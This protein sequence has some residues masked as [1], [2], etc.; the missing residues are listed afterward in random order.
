MGRLGWDYPILILSVIGRITVLFP[1]YFQ[2]TS[3]I[4]RSIDYD[5]GSRNCGLKS[6][7][8]ADWAVLINKTNSDYYQHNVVYCEYSYYY[9]YNKHHWDRTDHINKN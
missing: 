7:V 4:C 9:Q 6:M 2:K 3:F 5:S 8:A 1:I